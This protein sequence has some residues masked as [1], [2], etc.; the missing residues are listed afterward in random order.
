MLRCN[1]I[2]FC[3]LENEDIKAST[4]KH[5]SCT[6]KSKV[7]C[8]LSF[9][10]T[11]RY[12]NVL[13]WL[14]DSFDAMPPSFDLHATERSERKQ[15]R[16]RWLATVP[17]DKIAIREVLLMLRRQRHGSNHRDVS[18]AVQ[19]GYAQRWMHELFK[20]IARH[21]T[22]PVIYALSDLKHE[23]IKGRFYEPKIHPETDATQILRLT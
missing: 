5:F 22:I 20:I 9:R 23:P 6:L 21:P 1:D 19:K 12:I 10:N 3:N 16:T 18:H 2:H 14:V 13:Q 15:R 17:I 11:W 7:F 4:A 8:Y